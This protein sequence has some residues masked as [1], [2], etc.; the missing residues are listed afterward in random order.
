MRRLTPRPGCWRGRA[1]GASRGRPDPAGLPGGT[2]RRGGLGP[3]RRRDA[4]PPA[5]AC[6]PRA[7]SPWPRW[8]P[9]AASVLGVGVGLPGHPHRPARPAGLRRSLAALPLAVPTYVAGFAWVSTVDGFA[10]FWAAALV[11]TLCSYP[12]VYLPV[13]AALAGADPAQEEVARSLGPRTVARLR[14]RDAAPDPARGRRRARCSSRS[15][16]CRTSAPSP[17][18]RVDVFTRAIFT[19]INLGFDPHRRARARHRAG[20]AD[21]GAARRRDADPAPRRPL[22]PRRRRG[23]PPTRHGCALRAAAVA[24]RRWRWPPSPRS[25]WACRPLSLLR[26][27]VAGR[28]PA[29]DRSPRSPPRPATRCGSRRSARR[30]PSLLALPIGLL[31]ARAPGPLATLLDRLAYLAHALPGLVIGLSLVFFGINVAYPLY[32]TVWLLALAYAALFLPLAVGAVG[33]A[34]AQAPPA[35]E[36]VARSLGRRPAYVLRTVTLPLAAPGHR[37]RRGAGLPHLHEGT[38]G[39]AAAAPDRHG[40]ARHRAVDAHLGRRLRGRRAVRRAAG[41]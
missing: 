36:E 27:S 37:R 29:R 6:W 17:S 12:Y 7:A 21:R 18:L 28:V 25:L 3:D 35:L 32:Q 22:R 39:H 26:W 19:A 11:L 33:A 23:R 4:S 20:R 10:G 24:G 30:S 14:R 31:A 5:P 34:A 38:A 2:G 40:H 41:R 15:T 13:A 8:S 16:C 1:A 9:P